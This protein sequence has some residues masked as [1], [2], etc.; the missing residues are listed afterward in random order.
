MKDVACTYES[1]WK[2]VLVVTIICSQ[3]FMVA[4]S[5][6]LVQGGSP[7]SKLHR[8]LMSRELQGFLAFLVYL[9]SLPLRAVLMPHMLTI[10]CGFSH[11]HVGV[12]LC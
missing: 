10:R 1:L 5:R 7:H 9:A 12:Q 3:V 2:A 4:G 11:P 6:V 8:Q